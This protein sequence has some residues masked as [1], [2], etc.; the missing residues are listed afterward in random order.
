[1]LALVIKDASMPKLE[2]IIVVLRRM[3]VSYNGKKVGKTGAG[4]QTEGVVA[5]GMERRRRWKC[6]EELPHRS[7]RDAHP[8]IDNRDER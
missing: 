2:E 4:H 6:D 8:T 1:M 3:D 7:M 5:G